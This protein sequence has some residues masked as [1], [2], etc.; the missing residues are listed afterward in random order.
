MAPTYR[1][2]FLA[3]LRDNETAM[4]ALFRD[5]HTRIMGQVTRAAT[6]E[7]GVVPPEQSQALRNRISLLVLRTF[8][9]ADGP[10]AITAGRVLPSSP[11]AVVLWPRIEQATLI[12]VRE[13]EAIMRRA[14]RRAPDVLT[15]FERARRNPLV[16]ARVQEQVLP[17]R[18]FLTYDPAHRFVDPRGYRLSDRIWD[19]SATTRRKI[20]QLLAE[21]IAEGRGS[22]AM[23]RELEQF[24]LPGRRIM[25]TNKPYGTTA[26][27][28]AMRLSRTD[29]TAAHGRAGLMSAHMNPFVN[30]VDWVLSGSHP[31]VDICDE[32]A[33]G[34]PY[35]LADAPIL[36]AHPMDLCHYRWRVIGEISDVIDQLREDY[37]L[38]SPV[39]V[40]SATEGSLIWFVGPLL[41]ERFARI[42]LDEPDVQSEELF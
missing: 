26:S 16:T 34:S 36:P 7:D 2:R 20:D 12:A 37:R 40:A 29:I 32:Y 18:P 5:L 11:F 1:Q 24:L 42:L 17:R 30:G 22:R 31:K 28:D 4:N 10:F 35:A 14:L 39:A 25:R 19:T 38:G 6:G 27:F 41:A 15:A 8:Q 3:L 21:M 13:H 33:A 9:G 23:A